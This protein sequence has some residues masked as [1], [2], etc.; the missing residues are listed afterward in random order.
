MT[1][2]R[3]SVNREHPVKIPAP[4]FYW[5]WIFYHP[6]CSSSPSSSTLLQLQLKTSRQPQ[7]AQKSTQGAAVMEVRGSRRA[8]VRPGAA[9]TEQMDGRVFTSHG[10]LS[11]RNYL[12]WLGA[13]LN[14]WFST[15]TAQ[16]MVEKSFVFQWSRKRRNC[17]ISVS[18]WKQIAVEKHQCEPSTWCFIPKKKSSISH[19]NLRRT[20]VR[21]RGSRCGW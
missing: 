1:G 6:C 21:W 20:R 10:N 4:V 17:Q 3:L 8:K 16:R 12:R 7:P 11:R 14:N 2:V 13:H 9:A 15:F 5:Q 18:V 19:R